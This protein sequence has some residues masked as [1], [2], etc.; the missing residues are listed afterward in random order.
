MRLDHLLSKGKERVG[1]VHCCWFVKANKIFGVA[2]RNG[3]TPVLIPNT[4]VKTDTAESTLLETARE[5]RWLQH[6]KGN[7][8]ERCF[9][10]IQL[11]FENRISKDLI[12][13]KPKISESR[14]REFFT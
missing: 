11:H 2:I 9:T 10:Y 7:N 12:F 8:I 6:Q 1:G 14:H 5:D 4:T 3:A 13:L